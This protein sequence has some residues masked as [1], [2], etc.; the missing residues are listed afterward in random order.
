[1][2][3]RHPGAHAA[4]E[5]P[6][7]ADVGHL[8]DHDLVQEVANA[9][10]RLRLVGEHLVQQGIDVPVEGDA[11]ELGHEGGRVLDDVG[12]AGKRR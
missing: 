10:A 9:L 1:M 4:E 12:N 11:Q 7:L 6:A 2:N 3:A 8:V 5:V